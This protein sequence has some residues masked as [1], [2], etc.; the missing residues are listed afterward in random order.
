MKDSLS[1][2]LLVALKRLKAHVE[3]REKDLDHDIQ[4]RF[5][6]M[7]IHNHLLISTYR[8]PISRTIY[9]CWWGLYR[10]QISIDS[11]RAN[12]INL[13]QPPTA[14]TITYAE[15]FLDKL[16]N[17]EPSTPTLTWKDILAEEPFEGEHWEGILDTKPHDDHDWDSTPS[18]SPLSSDLED[19]ES[20]SNYSD[21]RRPHRTFDRDSE[22]GNE[23]ENEPRM[24]EEAAPGSSVP[25]HTYAHRREFEELQA[26]QYWRSEWKGYVQPSKRFNIGDPSTLGRCCFLTEMGEL[27][28]FVCRTRSRRCACKRARW[29]CCYP[30]F[31]ST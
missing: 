24:V 12:Q 31:A 4:V 11:Y 17:P 3:A 14:S 21:G 29:A 18:L 26:I 5:A 19:T 25:P 9:N 1:E 23:E 7:P 15:R 28:M 27:L 20:L 16:K 6:C 10:A 8:R 13:S 22:D 2:A 30:S